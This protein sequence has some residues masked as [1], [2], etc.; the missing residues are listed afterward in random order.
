MAAKR[1]KKKQGILARVRS[2]IRG[3]VLRGLLVVVPLGVTAYVLSFCYSITAGYLVPFIQ[4]Y[5]FLVPPRAVVP[6]SVVL[7]LAMLYLV[8][9]VAAAM[10]GR[11]L[12]A[13]TEAII[14]RIPLVKTVYGASKQV[15]E[16]ISRQEGDADYKA[17]VIVDFP[18]PGM[19][20]LA[21]VTGRIEIEGVGEMMKIF[22]PTTPNPTSGYLELVPPSMVSQSSMTVEDAVKSVM[23][24]GILTP[25]VVEIAAPGEKLS[26][27]DPS[28][29]DD[30]D[31]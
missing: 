25:E 21:F 13:L 17:A 29:E 15:V 5:L 18:C 11:Q 12:I 28:D 10:V 14:R 4:E 30:E 24:A 23:S 27:P 9:L 20:A 26:L 16:L 1:K 6:L 22:I 2:R 8:G 31:D 7:F 19:K 3:Y